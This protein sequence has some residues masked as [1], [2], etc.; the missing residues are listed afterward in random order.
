MD[1]FYYLQ[2]KFLRVSQNFYEFLKVKY[3]IQ[4]TKIS[5]EQKVSLV[6]FF[7][8]KTIFVYINFHKSQGKKKLN[9]CT[10]WEKLIENSNGKLIK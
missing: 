4:F 6:N 9:S 2:W 1:Y 7:K 10:K 8:L 5:F 3:G